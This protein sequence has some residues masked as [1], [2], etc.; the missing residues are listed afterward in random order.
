MAKP[1]L[2]IKLKHLNLALKDFEKF[3]DE[4]VKKFADITEIK[5][6]E[7]VADAKLKAP[8][9]DGLLFKSIRSKELNKLRWV[10]FTPVKY[11]PY[12][13]FGTGAKNVIVP[14]ELQDIAVHFK[15][16]DPN[17]GNITPRPFLYPAFVRARPLYIKDLDKALKKL[18]KKY[19]D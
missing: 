3:G 10:V 2:N 18:S 6:D 15:G 19:S 13:E 17:R 14:P 8:K 7:I 11:A 12:M 1:V 9:K 16:K 5:A 4:G